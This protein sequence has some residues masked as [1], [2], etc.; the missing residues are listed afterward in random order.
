[1]SFSSGSLPAAFTGSPQLRALRNRQSE[2]EENSIS[3]NASAALSLSSALISPVHFRLRSRAAMG[4]VPASTNSSASNT[5]PA[6]DASLTSLPPL[7][8][9]A[10]VKT[11]SA[12]VAT[13]LAS[14]R[15]P[16]TGRPSGVRPEQ[17]CRIASA[18]R[19]VR[20]SPLLSTSALSLPCGVSSYL[21][22]SPKNCQTAIAS[23]GSTEPSS[24]ASPGSKL[25]ARAGS[26]SAG[27]SDRHSTNARTRLRILFVFMETASLGGIWAGFGI[28]G[29]YGRAAG[30]LFRAR[31]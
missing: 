26:D 31:G 11:T 25:P 19:L 28:G 5:A 27:S 29:G 20:P 30:G 14:S 21:S 13:S 12:P 24:L 2:Y 8:V 7:A 15:A 6:P 3:L 16:T 1:M 18:S 23:D 9:S 17:N 10:K 22:V 4:F